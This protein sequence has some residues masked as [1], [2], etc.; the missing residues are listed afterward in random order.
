MYKLRPSL[1]SGH[2]IRRRKRRDEVILSRLR[3]GHCGLNAYRSIID[4]T[5]S[6]KCGHCNLE[7]PEN[8]SNYMPW[9]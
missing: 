5:V 1:K 3:L 8:I 7:T 2:K 6:S 9:A 4:K